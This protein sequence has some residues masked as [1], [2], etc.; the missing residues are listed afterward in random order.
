M[1]SY[2]NIVYISVCIYMSRTSACMYRA[3]MAMGSA[4]CKVKEAHACNRYMI[5][6]VQAMQGNLAGQRG[7][8]ETNI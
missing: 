7:G 6:V 2:N 8:F 3:R 4:L 1:H 5:E